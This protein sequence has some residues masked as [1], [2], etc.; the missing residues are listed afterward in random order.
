MPRHT[1]T[2]SHLE[3]SL[4][5]ILSSRGQMTVGTVALHI[6]LSLST[7]AGILHRLKTKGLATPVGRYGISWRAL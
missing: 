6:G 5:D 3:Q 1:N 2:P 4:L 7:T